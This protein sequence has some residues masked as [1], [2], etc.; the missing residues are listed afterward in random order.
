MPGRNRGFTLL[1]VLVALAILGI[2]LPALFY[3]LNSQTRNASEMRQRTL[4]NWVAA[5]Q[6]ELA[7]IHHRIGLPLSSNEEGDAVMG[8]GHWHWSRRVEPA[9]DGKMLR[10]TISVKDDAKTEWS[11]L[12]GLMGQ[13]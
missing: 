2:A 11:Q 3:A 10:V 12:V 5:N 8:E 13:P 1:E 9:S 4:A 6:M 7:G